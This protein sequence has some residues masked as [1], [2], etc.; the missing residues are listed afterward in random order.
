MKNLDKRGGGRRET[1][2]EHSVLN[3]EGRTFDFTNEIVHNSRAWMCCMNKRTMHGSNLDPLR[4]FLVEL[5]ERSAEH[6][7]HGTTNDRLVIDAY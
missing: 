2:I 7:V 6:K 4:L 1:T 5:I 3:I